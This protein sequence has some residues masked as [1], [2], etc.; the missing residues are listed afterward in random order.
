MISDLFP[1]S[2]NTQKSN[3]EYGIFM[4]MPTMEMLHTYW[5]RLVNSSKYVILNANHCLFFP[6]KRERKKKKHE[7]LL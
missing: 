6:L 4:V 5:P 1:V 2:I 3:Y 7:T